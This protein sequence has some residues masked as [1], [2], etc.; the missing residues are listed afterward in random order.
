MEEA[1]TT[2]LSCANGLEFNFG[3]KGRACEDFMSSD[4]TFKIHLSSS[5]LLNYTKFQT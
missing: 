2:G 3:G 5:P 1:S 4:S